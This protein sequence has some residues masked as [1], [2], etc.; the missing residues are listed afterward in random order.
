MFFH[1]KTGLFIGDPDKKIFSSTD[2][3]DSKQKDEFLKTS[4]FSVSGWRRV[5]A[6]DGNE[7]S[8]NPEI[9]MLDKI[10]V[11]GAARL[12]SEFLVKTKKIHDP[13]I[14]V[15]IDSRHTG[16]EIAMVIIKT[17]LAYG[18]DVRYIFI[19]SAPEIM[20]YTK[21]SDEI[22]GFMYVT[23]SHNPIGHNGLKFGLR[24]GAVLGKTEAQPIIDKF[25]RCFFDQSWVNEMICAVDNI[26][27]ARI[28]GIF[29]NIDKYKAQAID[30][31]CAFTDL[32]V[33]GIED[34]KK[35]E[36]MMQTI[37]SMITQTGIGV[38]AELN[39]SA[40]AVSI[41]KKYLQNMGIDV[42]AINDKPRQFVHRIVPEGISLDIAKQELE[43]LSAKDKK[44]RFAYVPDC[45]GD[46]GNVVTLDNYG[47]SSVLEAQ[48]VFALS[49]VSEL[50]Y[51]VFAG[52]LTYDTQ[53]KPEQKVAVI[54]NGPTS[55]RIEKIAGFF[56]AEVFRAEVGEAN[57]VSLAQKK[58]KEGYIVRIL[59]EG[60][61]G[62][63]ITLPSTVRDP[64]NTIFAFIKMLVLKSEK[65]KPGLFE[66]WC[67]RSGQ[68]DKFQQGAELFDI[69]STLPAYTTTSAF[70][71]RA[72]VK[73]QTGD[74][75]QLKANYEHIFIKEWNENKEAL[76]E[77][78]G[79]VNY[80]VVNHE[81]TETIIGMGPQFR[82]GS[83]K[84][85]F[86]IVFLNKNNRCT[87]FI[88]M[89]GSGTEPV[90]RVL[91][92]VE[93]KNQQA[94]KFLLD[95]HVSMIKKADTY[96]EP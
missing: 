71:E 70:D 94:E 77:K 38:L 66:I 53:G 21:T 18:C 93:G 89:R 3:F 91:A 78:F 51:L 1:E 68:I 48:E 79:I 10:M 87:A 13:I 86:K 36:K 85:D 95:W 42:V 92:D 57:V 30:K 34:D 9:G 24:D 26:P 74:H 59:G 20:A 43:K 27:C 72:M 84:G 54:V 55:C 69:V 37:K 56:G 33:T 15:G 90:F 14:V 65:N 76:S 32:V 60:S 2:T 8:S 58:L 35:R 7:E 83:Q 25:L 47:K 82:T 40:R 61:N 62:G 23:A 41:D 49:V 73:I 16:P 17:L 29:N 63:N 12:F 6:L 46:R 96:Q 81:G 44:F 75:A 67:S 45:D 52:K 88:W 11:A 4:I 80:Q 39:G 31:Y 5:F 64:I 28:T 22:D 50:S 19:S